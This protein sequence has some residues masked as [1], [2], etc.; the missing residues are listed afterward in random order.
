LKLV[1]IQTKTASMFPFLFGTVYSIYR[2][3]TIKGS[4]FFTM[5]ISLLLFDMT[6]TA[7]NNYMD[8]C[9]SNDPDYKKDH[10]II[11]QAH[12]NLASVRAVILIMLSGAVLSGLFLVYLTTPLVLFLGGISFFVGIFY[13]FG[14][15]PIS[16]MP[17]GEILSGFLM[18]FVIIYLA[19]YIHNPSLANLD[20]N[21]GRIFLD[22][23]LWETGALFI[24]SL[25]FTLGISNLML[26]NNICDRELDITNDRFL[27]P[28]YIG[29]KKSLLVFKLSYYL[30]FLSI[31][32][33]IIAGI[34]PLISF[35]SL[36]PFP[37]VRKNIKIFE[38]KQIKGETFILSVKNLILI[39]LS[40][41]LPLA[42]YV[43]FQYLAA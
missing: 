32:L 29:V 4:I 43:L 41:L 19:V 37:I 23:S 22:F 18:G 3:G 9:K 11:G 14:P 40:C 20:Y 42:G 36:T 24:V 38:T 6:T 13:T 2:F 39:S 5:L 35:L 33:S 15:I 27:L 34:L 1:E 17:L 8:Y 21:S 31:I 25:P 28:Y 30:V 16:R 12:L 10:N 7:V 26:A